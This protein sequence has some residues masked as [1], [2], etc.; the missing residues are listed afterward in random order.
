MSG[1]A[2]NWRAILCFGSIAVILVAGVALITRPAVEVVVEIEPVLDCLEEDTIVKVWGGEHIDYRNPDW[3]GPIRSGRRDNTLSTLALANG[4]VIEN[5]QEMFG[6]NVTDPLGLLNVHFFHLLQDVT[7]STVIGSA[8]KLTGE[9]W[10]VTSPCNPIW[11]PINY[12]PQNVYTYYLFTGT[13]ELITEPETTRV[14]DTLWE[15][16]HY[17]KVIT[18]DDDNLVQFEF[19]IE[20]VVSGAQFQSFYVENT[21]LEAGAVYLMTGAL[22]RVYTFSTEIDE[23][24]WINR[25]VF[26]TNIK[27]SFFP[28]SITEVPR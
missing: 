14:E 27:Y 13:I 28:D 18:I 15:G 11:Y 10:E 1:V 17:D 16:E 24:M 21:T 20:N 8:Y 25:D 2:R 9:L 26:T 12:Q 5:I 22:K 6:E 4:F 3:Q 19:G 7:P 23:Y